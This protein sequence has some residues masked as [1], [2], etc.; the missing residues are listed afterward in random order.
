MA[1]NFPALLELLLHQAAFDGWLRF[2]CGGA[3][4]SVRLSSWQWES[5]LVLNLSGIEFAIFWLVL[6]LWTKTGLHFGS[7]GRV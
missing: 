4:G 6:D 3:Y 1:L 5:E 2:T 7:L